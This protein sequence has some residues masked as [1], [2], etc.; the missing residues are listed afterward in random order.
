MSKVLR[1]EFHSFK[2]RIVMKTS[3][4]SHFLWFRVQID[5]K[6]SQSDPSSSLWQVKVNKQ[7]TP[8]S[9]SCHNKRQ[10]WVN[11]LIWSKPRIIF[12]NC[13]GENSQVK[14]MSEWWKPRWPW[15]QIRLATWN[16]WIGRDWRLSEA[17]GFRDRGG[18][19]AERMFGFFSSQRCKKSNH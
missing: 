6:S 18:I 9:K 15:N 3:K 19:L 10:S 2:K 13:Q 5:S 17:R 12:G 16:R 4:Q 11:W 14:W 8:N 7:V 1:Q